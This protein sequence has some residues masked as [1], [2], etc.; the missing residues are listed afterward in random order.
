MANALAF[1]GGTSQVNFNGLQ[2]GGEFPFLNV[3]KTAQEWQFIDGSGVPSPSVLNSDGY[4]TSISNGGV[5]TRLFIPIQSERPG[6][7]KITWSGSGTIYFNTGFATLT[8]GATNTSGFTVT[9]T[10]ASGTFDIGISAGTNISNLQIFHVSDETA[11][12][13]G[14]IF[15]VKFKQRLVEANFGVYRFLNWQ[16]GNDTNI[17]L[18]AHRKPTTYVFYRGLEMRSGLYVSS[19]ATLSGKTYSC[20]APVTWPGL[21]HGAIAHITFASASPVASVVCTFTNGSAAIAATAHGCSVNDLVRLSTSSSLPTNFL[22]QTTYFVVSIADADHMTVA[23][24]QGGTAIIAGSAG[25]G[26]H[27]VNPMVLLNVGSTGAV[28][29]LNSSAQSM[30]TGNNS[31]P[32][33]GKIATVIYDSQ[34]GTWIKKGGDIALGNYGLANGVPP[35]IMVQLCGEMGAHPY[36][37]SPM[38][39]LDPV[40]TGD[41][42]SGLATYCRDNA[43][44]WMIPRFE[45]T[46]EPWNGAF[47]QTSY[48]RAKGKAYGWGTFSELDW[49]GKAM[50]L[51]G[52]TISAVYSADRTKY[53]VILGLQTVS[54]SSPTSNNASVDSTQ[55]VSAGGSAAKN[56]ITHLTCSQYICPSAFAGVGTTQQT[57]LATRYAAGDVS[58][59]ISYSDTCLGPA[60]AGGGSNNLT[61][62]DLIG[63]YA[64]LKTYAQSKGINKVCGYEGGLSPDYI[65]GE[66]AAV[67]NLKIASKNSPNNR[68]YL[69]AAFTAFTQLTDATFTAEFP[70]QYLIG[71]SEPSGFAW[72]AFGGTIYSANTPAWDALVAWGAVKRAANFRLGIHG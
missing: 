16:D 31:Y 14:D 8:T 58:A 69:I 12:L 45:G 46:N 71:D 6:N 52:Q 56:W 25:V 50:S 32:V 29:I 38:F 51:L 63:Y 40:P 22:E 60:G 24:T 21:I 64:N 44:S 2:T 48:G 35:E 65:G 39:S 67:R 33:T 13:A 68:S 53:N 61:V 72:S 42:Q 11:V 54:L 19:A 59:P 4:P 7:Y 49:L 70:S 5:F 36:F 66:A 23:L 10:D 3:L 28:P 34:L 20:S 15:G 37:V 18:W 43:P 62:A 17:S 47:D 1:N 57:D 41:Y 55:Y 30:K 27:A 26:P 9:P